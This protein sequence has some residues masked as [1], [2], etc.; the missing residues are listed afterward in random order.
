[1][2]YL[3]LSDLRKIL[4]DAKDENIFKDIIINSVLK[5]HHDSDSGK[6]MSLM[7]IAL[8]Q[9]NNN[10]VKYFCKHLTKDF[11]FHHDGD[12]K[13]IINTT[14]GIKKIYETPKGHE[15]Y[16][17]PKGYPMFIFFKNK[18]LPTY[19][20]KGSDITEEKEKYFKNIFK[21]G[22]IYDI[23]DIIR[24]DFVSIK[25]LLDKK[26]RNEEIIVFFLANTNDQK[27]LEFIIDY[28]KDKPFL[29]SMRGWSILDV[30]IDCQN[31]FACKYLINNLPYKYLFKEN[32]D[33]SVVVLK[34]TKYN[35][36]EVFT[37][38]TNKEKFYIDS[39]GKMCTNILNKITMKGSDIL[40]A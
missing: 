2:S 18:T 1:M 20:L 10:A 7:D 25:F 29:A 36:R 37:N 5:F 4:S 6:I 12:H 31:V 17:S 32:K 28:M 27:A 24:F 33:Y 19:I 15:F 14:S 9:G 35:I 23:S 16:L 40:K 22:Q 30:P 3:K 8:E 11:I 38:P 39:D 13:V 26:G 21:Y 34:D